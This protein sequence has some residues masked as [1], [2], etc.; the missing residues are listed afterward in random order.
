MAK[1]NTHGAQL[2]VSDGAAT[3]VFTTVAQLESITLPSETRGSEDVPTHDDAAGS[4]MT[5]VVDALRSAGTMSFTIVEDWAD[6]S[7]DD[8]TGL[9][10]LISGGE[11]TDFRI[12]LPDDAGTEID[13]TGFVSSRTPQAMPAN[14]GV[15]RVDY[16]I[17]LVSG[18]T[19]T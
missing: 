11:E 7:H 19:I 1:Y 18:L 9:Y 15:P 8:T 4:I 17:T 2:Q 10:S 14:R 3:P 13:F 5:K 6:G 16:E 12:I